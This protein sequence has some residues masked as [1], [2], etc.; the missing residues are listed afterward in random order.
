VRSVPYL[1]ISLFF[2]TGISPGNPTTFA[3]PETSEFFSFENDL[4]GWTIKGTDLEHG[5]GFI[6][7]SITRTQDMAKDGAS[8]LRFLIN[9]QND[10]GKIWIEKPFSV[11]PSQTYQVSV[12]YALAATEPEN[13][14]PLFVI[15]T[16]VQNKSPNTRDDLV[17][18]YKD[19]ANNGTME[20]GYK[21]VEKKYEFIARSDEQAKL[22]VTI[23]IWGIWEVGKIFYFDSVRVTLSKK[24]E[25]TRF[26]SFENDFEGWMPRAADVE[27]GDGSIDW[28]ITHS[29]EIWEDGV[30][31]VKF[32]LNDLNENGKIWIE[33]TF[34][35][36]PKKKYKITLD[37]AFHSAD[38]GDAP[39]FRII[40]GVFRKQPQSGDDLTDAFQE[41]TTSCAWGWLHKS[42]QFTLKSKKSD[43]L[44]VV[45]GIKGIQEDHRTYNFDSVCVTLTKK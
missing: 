18:A 24:P 17:P 15:I 16:G 36:E 3:S 7:W 13:S 44:Y 11:E 31:S 19:G 26:F 21:W 38:C 14:G 35:V 25:E 33:R 23:G 8:S 29:K 43:V 42:Y 20:P 45:I 1:L 2:L 41:K 37:Y 32:D 9:N 34:S 4:E 5:S 12:E 28:S 30:A 27:L 6:D 40:T 22:Y 39:R 10:A